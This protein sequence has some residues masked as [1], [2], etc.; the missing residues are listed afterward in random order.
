[1]SLITIRVGTGISMI[2]GT[3]AMLRIGMAIIRLGIGAGT[4]LITATD[5]VVL[6]MIIL[7]MVIPMGMRHLSFV[8]PIDQQA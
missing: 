4:T 7:T 3:E 8:A 5:G 6:I 2:P 1:M